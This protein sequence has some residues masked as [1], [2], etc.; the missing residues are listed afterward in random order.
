MTNS[1]ILFVMLLYFSNKIYALDAIQIKYIKNMV[2]S[3]IELDKLQLNKQ[4]LEKSNLYNIDKLI[5]SIVSLMV[6]ILIHLCFFIWWRD[7]LFIVSYCQ[8][9]CLRRFYFQLY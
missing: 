7:R 5:I 4:H 1:I 2:V 3:E 9:I 8:L 6:Q